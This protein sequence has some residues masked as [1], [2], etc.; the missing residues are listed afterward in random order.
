[1][2]FLE[3]DTDAID[4]SIDNLKEKIYITVKE[5]LVHMSIMELNQLY[6]K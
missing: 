6:N 1:M 3:Y 2:K 5:K 4:E